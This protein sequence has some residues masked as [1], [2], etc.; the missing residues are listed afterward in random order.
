MTL[1]L[2]GLKL[3]LVAGQLTMKAFNASLTG[4]GAAA[5]VA[6]GAIGA[7][8]AAVR[9]LKAAQMAPLLKS[10]AATM[11]GVPV[12]G[13]TSYKSSAGVIGNL[14][15]D[16]RFGMFSDAA[17]TSMMSARAQAGQR[18]DAPFRN[19]LA[20]LADFSGGDEKALTSINQ[21][22]INGAKAGKV[23]GEVYQ[24]LQKSAPMLAKAF[25]EMTGGEEAA[26]KA[27]DA[28][29]MSF[30]KFNEAIMKGE[31]EAL[32]PYNGALNEINNTVI[33]KLKGG[34][35]T[36]KEDL[37]DLGSGE[38]LDA[39][40]APIDGM[41]QT[42]SNSIFAVAGALQNTIPNMLGGVGG[43]TTTVMEK[44]VKY[45]IRGMTA[46]DG[47]G[48]TLNTWVGNIRQ[49]FGV[50][51]SYLTEVTGPW[52]QFS[53]Q[54][55]MPLIKLLGTLF[56]EY[57]R[58]FDDALQKNG[59]ALEMWKGALEGSED[60]IKGIIGAL[61]V[62]KT[63]LTPIIGVFLQLASI[64]GGLL[65]TGIGQFVGGFV[66]L[67]MVLIKSIR[68]FQ[69]W[70]AKLIETF[71]ALQK[72]KAEMDAAKASMDP[73]QRALDTVNK[74]ISEQVALLKQ[75]TTGWKQM[76]QFQQLGLPGAKPQAAIGPG[77]G[78]NPFNKPGG[79]PGPGGIWRGPGMVPGIPGGPVGFG[80]GLGGAGQGIRTTGGFNAGNSFGFSAS[81]FSDTATGAN[82]ASL[83]KAMRDRIM[84][85]RL[86]VKAMNTDAAKALRQR[87][88]YYRQ[89][90]K[91]MYEMDRK[92]ATPFT[93]KGMKDFAR[94]GMPA[95]S[96]ES[97]LAAYRQ[98]MSSL[99]ANAAIGLM[100]AG[101]M[102]GGEA[103]AAMGGI[104]TGVMLGQMTGTKYGGIAGAMAGGGLALGGMIRAKNPTSRSAQM[105]GG[106]LQYGLSAA[107]AGLMVPG[108]PQVKAVAAIVLGIIGTAAGAKL[109]ADAAKDAAAAL[110]D[111]QVAEIMEPTTRIKTSRRQVNKARA[112][113]QKNLDRLL[114]AR[115]QGTKLGYETKKAGL[116][117]QA[118]RTMTDIIGFGQISSNRL[119]TGQKYNSLGSKSEFEA[120]GK[121]IKAEKRLAEA[122]AKGDKEAIIAA[123]NRLEELRQLRKQL[124]ADLKDNSKKI[125]TARLGLAEFD[126]QE[127]SVK[128]S[129]RRGIALGFSSKEIQAYAQ[130][131]NKNLAE[132]ALGINS[133]IEMSGFAGQTALEASKNVD[134]MRMAMEDMGVAALRATEYFTQEA[135]AAKDAAEAA[136]R[137]NKTFADFLAGAN[138]AQ[139]PE[140]L[141]I[142]LSEVLIQFSQNLEGNFAQGKYG[143]GNEGFATY[144]ARQREG[145]AGM[146]EDIKNRPGVRPEVVAQAEEMFGNLIKKTTEVGFAQLMQMNP[147]FGATIKGL[148]ASI[149]SKT[150]GMSAE[151]TEE[152]INKRA[153]AIDNYMT[154]YFGLT[155][156]AI[157]S[158]QIA[159]QLKIDMMNN[160]NDISTKIDKA[161]T[162]GGKKAARSLAA[163]FNSFRINA[164]AT[165]DKDGKVS[166]VFKGA[167]IASAGG[168][169]GS[170]ND[171]KFGKGGVGDTSSS[172]RQFARSLASHSMFNSMV[173]GSRNILSGL[174]STGLGSPSSDHR[175]GYAYDL[176]GQNLGAYASLVKASGGFAEFHGAAGGRHLHVVP[177]HGGGDTMSPMRAATAV[178]PMGGG[179]V[180][181]NSYSIVVNGGAASPAEIAD[182]VMMR[183]R[184]AERNA[185][186]RA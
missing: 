150:A 81:S 37:T 36:L 70:K 83:R 170:G 111:E 85:N 12:P 69:E 145:A 6:V 174:R 156:D 158:E 140:D 129:M 185:M 133:Y 127:A 172:R 78:R 137:F 120:T 88:G 126:R 166:M 184:R 43:M 19:Q 161:H 141:T 164:E 132:V 152:Y 26:A 101:G 40:R 168:D 51:G 99:K 124:D 116:G 27:A 84:S 46:I 93:L 173:P 119:G 10:V 181:N 95:G 52:D 179:A 96:R 125:A 109:G 28:G 15:A 182:E 92:S 45:I 30:E 21:A 169:S 3:A 11:P 87:L 65:N 98:K 178:A 153:T 105:T 35:R 20:R 24:E 4:L 63:I 90:H 47:L 57:L 115:Q 148:G 143:Y 118:W 14:M 186:E 42:I 59:G 131:N 94:R 154:A 149:S 54:V 76:V 67:R 123:E 159:A 165:V 82:K 113:Q 110:F 122:K 16:K 86:M 108:P 144:L 7:V 29:T 22:M 25:E 74:R 62:V 146:L 180:V 44:L 49:F 23:T 89:F 171:W 114:N 68:K 135:V 48:N 128:L 5:G 41:V 177:P 75:A 60:L 38:I 1:V 100:T 13:G 58:G 53:N 61:N 9:E 167:A 142:G 64:F 50:I 162:D 134:T 117:D 55:I 56:N 130:R 18:V 163:V 107:S 8:L 31:L 97:Q 155:D 2:G 32:K 34:F 66:L 73:L 139:T 151:K 103:G 112:D 102:M 160:G 33:G 136:K 17:L 72:S 104:G 71:S 175:F 91:S 77:G 138:Q 147:E 106:A 183:I 121:F 176:T 39:V 79:S 80:S 157:K